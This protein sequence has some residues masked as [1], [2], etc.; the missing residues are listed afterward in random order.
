MNEYQISVEIDNNI[1]LYL[2]YLL[3]IVLSH[4][5]LSSTKDGI[6]EESCLMAK[7]GI[8]TD[9]THCLPSEFI[10]RYGIKVIPMGL[11]I[12]NRPYYEQVEITAA[13]FWEKFKTL[14]SL[15]TTFA[16]NP[17]EFEKMFA[18]MA[19]GAESI[20][21]ILVS[22]I[23]TATHNAAISAKKNFLEQNPAVR[24]EVIDSKCAAG[25]LGFLVLEAARAIE[26]G[27]NFEQVVNL[28]QNMLSKVTYL[29][30]LET[31]K[32]LIKGGRA[33]KIAAIGN[34]L[35]VR[36]IIT[37]NK[38]TGEVLTISRGQG[39]KNTMAK[40]VNMVGDFVEPNKPLHMIV[41]Y[42]NNLQDGEKLREMIKAKYDCEELYM[43]PYSP[44]MAVHVGPVISLAFYTG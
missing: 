25:A 8:L 26:R 44:V 15:P 37:N 33:P 36:P 21:C 10:R 19:L 16:P 6:N 28:V 34:L 43:T 11:V 32:Y 1:D 12:N 13:E 20:I 17:K 5:N 42:T 35:G 38:Q 2:E 3:A 7:I 29:T 4:L 30:A 39:K 23:L 41:H 24:I 14:K 22:K 18:E 9:T 40:L 31:T 27:S